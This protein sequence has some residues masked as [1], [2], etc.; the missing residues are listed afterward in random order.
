MIL[1]S[2]LHDMRYDSENVLSLFL[3]ISVSFCKLSWEPDE[4][5]T[6]YPLLLILGPM[7]PSYTLGEFSA[8]IFSILLFLFIWLNISPVVFRGIC[9]CFR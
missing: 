1:G 4:V 2:L 7:K 3:S 9:C 6:T 5:P 8:L